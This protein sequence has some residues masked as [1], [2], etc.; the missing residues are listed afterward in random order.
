MSQ[1]LLWKKVTSSLLLASMLTHISFPVYASVTQRVTLESINDLL[2]VS[3]RYE[4]QKSIAEY[5]YTSRFETDE[6]GIFDGF[7][8]FYNRLA[9]K[10]SQLIPGYAKKSN[11]EIVDSLPPRFGTPY[12]E[13]GVIRHQITQILNKNWISSPEFSSYNAQTKQL[14]ENA[15]TLALE[16][17]YKLGQVLSVEQI[18]KINKDVIWP[19]IRTLGS[20]QKPYL[21]PFVYLTDAT[22]KQQKIIESTYHANSADIKTQT[23]IVDG[24][25]VNFA[26]RAMI[27]VEK[28]FINTKGNI[29]GSKLT[30]RTGRELQN[31]SGTIT[32]DD[33]TLLANKLTN[34]TLVTRLDYGHGYSEKFSQ[35]GTISSLGNLTIATTSDVISH[36]GKFSAQGDLTI[37]AGGNIILVPQQAKNERHESGARW[38]DNESSLV[39]L[40]TNLSAIDTLKLIAGGQIHIEGA[41]LESQGLIELLAGYGITLKS[42]ADL[43]SFEKRFQASSGGVFG[44]K[45]SKAESKTEAEIV[46]TLLKAGQSMLLSTKQGDILLEAVTIDNK[47]IS[48]IIAEN[49]AIDFELAKLLE[50]YSYENSYEGSLSF[51]HTGNGYQREV[52]YYSEF[53]NNGGLVLD[54]ATGVKIQVA[55]DSQNLD[56]T[57]AD[58][59]RAPELA[60]MQELRNNPEYSE[61]DWQSIELVLEQWDYDQSGLSPAA[62]AI[63]AIAVSIAMGPGAGSALAGTGTSAVITVSSPALAAALNAGLSSIVV[64]ASGSLLANGFDIQETLTQLS[65]K[66]SL[67]SLATSMVTAGVL[68][69]LDAPMFS[70]A[71]G[72]TLTL[73]DVVQNAT[74]S[75]LATQAIMQV[76]QAT[77]RTGINAIA[78]GYDWDQFGS[79]LV[80]SLAISSINLLGKEF[81]QQIGEAARTVRID[82]AQQ[83]ILHAALGCGLGMLTSA[84]HGGNTDANRIGCASGAGGGVIGEYVGSK[85]R[86]EIGLLEKDTKAFIEKIT[87][88]FAEEKGTSQLTPESIQAEVSKLHARGVDIARLVAGLTVF[89]MRGN[90][91][92]AIDT[93]GNAAENNALF[94]LVVLVS[95]QSAALFTA[96]IAAY[97]ATQFVMSSVDAYHKGSELYRIYLYGTR[98]EQ[99]Q[100][101]EEM[102]DLAISYSIE[103]GATILIGGAAQKVTKELLRKLDFD[104]VAAFLASQLRGKGNLDASEVYDQVAKNIKF[105]DKHF[106]TY[107]AN[108][109]KDDHD[110]WSKKYDNGRYDALKNNKLIPDND[111][112]MS[113][114]YRHKEMY[115]NTTITPER[116]T[117][118]HNKGFTIGEKGSWKRIDTR[119]KNVPNEP[120]YRSQKNEVTLPISAEQDIARYMQKEVTLPPD[121]TKKT[122]EQVITLRQKAEAEVRVLSSNPDLNRDALLNLK[123]DIRKYGDVLGSAK[124]EHNL[125]IEFTSVK[126]LP[127]EVPG[128]GQQGQFDGIWL[129]TD[130]NG[131]TT[132]ITG[133]AKAGKNQVHYN[134]RQVGRDKNDNIIDAQ[135]T[136]AQYYKA[137]WENMQKSFDTAKESSKYQSDLLYKKQTDELGQTLD[138]FKQ[139]KLSSPS[140][141]IE[142]R[143]SELIFNEN[144]MI[145]K[146]NNLKFETMH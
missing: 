106:E 101:K 62:M 72:T 55:A 35:I 50:S 43:R 144:G 130:K 63:L 15:V 39:N 26:H 141:S 36:G 99:A 104:D 117:E 114:Y 146:A 84:T 123:A 81:A 20:Q 82:V 76:F 105:K 45:E 14:Y 80:Q 92:I 68:S 48:K 87:K 131:V 137:I 134:H 37:N 95:P 18:K 16:N 19:E 132:L 139:Y 119:P 145:K 142:Y 25:K 9:E 21:V 91:D 34:K 136:S 57:L 138:L 52:A 17:N 38:Q 133:E 27:D 58:L 89:A 143:G 90:V 3:P 108:G 118:Q 47:G 41:Q 8:Y 6:I 127:F 122:V 65:S 42:A 60:W 88:D 79:S 12:V 32:G 28:D 11:N 73:T 78:R 96:A 74:G 111:V 59:A 1:S 54:A 49:G 67:V 40:Q 102:V 61:V 128:R 33:V 100:A 116:F 70:G 4:L 75:Q 109:G 112:D 135:Q 13:R 31:N 2:I 93:A 24:V 113:D 129:A 94:L 115:P 77:A 85:Y 66:E 110:T 22:I 120:S 5:L 126:K 51:R 121:V 53:I 140:S 46:R 64:Q 56:Q 69:G 83:Y 125:H 23:F 97:T 107:K 124:L 71:D 103:T 10:K 86:E 44:T 30:I 29:K 98:E 7:N